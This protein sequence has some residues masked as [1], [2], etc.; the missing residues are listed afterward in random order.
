MGKQ[1]NASLG[2][3]RTRPPFLFALGLCG[4]LLGACASETSTAEI[5]AAFDDGLKDYDAGN[6]ADAYK[7]WKSIDE[8][9]LAAMRNVALMLRTGKGVRKDPEAARGIMEQAAAA[10][11]VTAQADLG[12]MLLNGEGG[13]PDP[14]AAIPWLQMAADA[15]HPIAAYQLGLLYEQGTAVPKDVEKARKLYEVA[16][17]AGMTEAEDRL[18]ALPPQ[19]PQAAAAAPASAAPPPASP[20]PASPPPASP[21]PPEIPP[22]D[23]RH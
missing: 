6:Y 19:A 7:K 22:L 5:K 3:M 12:E 15:G 9:D 17:K 21:S 11:L 14:K 18:K 10:G 2:A 23:L 8:V 1:G 4:V 13:Q 16:A 20:P